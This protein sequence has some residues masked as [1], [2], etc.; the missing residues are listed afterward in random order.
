VKSLLQCARIGHLVRARRLEAK[1]NGIGQPDVRGSV[2]G[3]PGDHVLEHRAR[4]ELERP[5]REHGA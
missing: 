5:E 1:G 3:R 2:V 4:I